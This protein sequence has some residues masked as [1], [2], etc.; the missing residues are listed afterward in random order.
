M[1][2]Q[3]SQPSVLGSQGKVLPIPFAHATGASSRRIRNTLGSVM[4]NCLNSRISWQKHR[5]PRTV[6]SFRLVVQRPL[7]VGGWVSS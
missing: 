4:V 2:S 3:G 1:L 5:P 7:M 6:R